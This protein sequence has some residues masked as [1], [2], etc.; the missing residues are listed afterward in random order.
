M[1]INSSSIIIGPGYSTWNGGNFRFG[2]GG[3]K[4]KFLKNLRE[5]SAEEFGRFDSIQTK[6]RIT[7]SA[8]LWSGWENLS[9]IMP[10]AAFNPTI[11]GKLFGTGNLPLVIAGQDGSLLTVVNVQITKLA[12]LMLSVEK[13][14]F[15]ADIEFT[16]LLKSGYTPNQAGAYYTYTTGNSYNAPAFNKTN[17][18]AP[19]LS[20]AWAGTLMNGGAS[21]SSFSFKNGAAIDFKFEL[22]Y[23]PCDVDGYGEVDAIV[24]GFEGSC[25]GTPIGAL[26]ADIASALLPAQNLGLLEGSNGAGNLTLTFGSNSLILYQCF[27]AENDGFA[28]ARKNN[29][30]GEI[31]FRT[32]VPFSAGAMTARAA[33]S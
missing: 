3:V 25:K 33:A 8:R 20:A 24:N 16:G 1:S 23:E 18:R 6:R 15:S 29:R 22:D 27:V 9:L 21:L 28:W 30:I 19:V 32:T 2:D 11:G 7:V 4:A 13:E 31:T 14:L 12:N 26:E 17:F 10:S 5:I